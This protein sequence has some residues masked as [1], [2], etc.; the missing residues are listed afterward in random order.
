[1][2]QPQYPLALP[3]FFKSMEV[4]FTPV[5]TVGVSTSPQTL[6][7]Q[8]YEFIG[9]RWQATIE[10]P[11]MKRRTAEQIIGFLLSLNGQAGTF[12]LGDTANRV[13]QGIATGAPVCAGG[14]VQYSNNLL[15]TGWTANKTGILLAGDWLQMYSGAGQR[16]YKVCA[17][18]NSDGSGN[19]PLTVW[20]RLRDAA[21]SGSPL[22]TT[23][24][25]GIFYLADNVP[26]SIDVTKI[27]KLKLGAVESVF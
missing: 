21:P 23:N 4:T 16:L 8:Q 1:M 19:A 6:I 20:P 10:F 18:A 24:A 7:E 26:W 13:A 3:S 17:D 9:K 11:A 12:Y 22:I 5:D 27:Y 15:T 2:P 14:N 25:Q